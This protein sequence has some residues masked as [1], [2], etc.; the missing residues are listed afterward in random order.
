MDDLLEYT[1]EIIGELSSDPRTNL[2]KKI[3][4]SIKMIITDLNKRFQLDSSE[5]NVLVFN[6]DQKT[7]KNCFWW[8]SKASNFNNQQD[9]KYYNIENG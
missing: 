5:V 1:G 6:M 4:F 8:K 9:L 7:E 2:F 3:I